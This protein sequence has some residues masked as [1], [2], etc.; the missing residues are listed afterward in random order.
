MVRLDQRSTQPGKNIF[1]QINMKITIES[2]SEIIIINELVPV[3]V[4]MGKTE[5]GKAV[6]C[7]IAAMNIETSEDGNNDY[8]EFIRLST[9][10]LVT[11]P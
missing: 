6:I 1:K 5:D 2:T 3:R 9:N 11:E 4:W 7:Y 10:S 8:P